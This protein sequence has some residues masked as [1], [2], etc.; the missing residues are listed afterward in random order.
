MGRLFGRFA[1]SVPFWFVV[2]FILS[3]LTGTAI[4]VF[5]EKVS[6]DPKPANVF[7]ELLHILEKDWLYPLNRQEIYNCVM[8]RVVNEVQ[9]HPKEEIILPSCFQ[10]DK[11]ISLSQ[12]PHVM[13]E[14]IPVRFRMEA[15]PSGIPDVSF[16][17][18]S[19]GKIIPQQ[20]NV[21]EYFTPLFQRMH[22]SGV[23]GYVIDLA[24]NIGGFAEGAAVFLHNLVSVPKHT[25]R[26]LFEIKGK[27]STIFERHVATKSGPAADACISILVNSNTASAAEIIALYLQR[28]QHAFVVGTPTYNKWLAQGRRPLSDGSTLRFT[29]GQVYFEHNNTNNG[30]GVIPDFITN[31]PHTRLEKAME[32]LRECHAKKETAH[33]TAQK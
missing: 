12:P 26:L 16:G 2:V 7:E 25:E 14:I 3:T 17:S 28:Y 10:Q 31:D 19:L 33:I 27:N 4:F 24:D 1:S 21:N 29:L 9:L 20:K 18:I 8:A 30:L 13:E 32:Y 22:E 6:S 5:A 15:T 23:S 11:Y